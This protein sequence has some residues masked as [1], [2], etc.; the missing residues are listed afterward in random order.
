MDPSGRSRHSSSDPDLIGPS[1]GCI[2]LLPGCRCPL[3]VAVAAPPSSIPR[4]PVVCTT[5]VFVYVAMHKFT[6]H[7]CVGGKK[8]S[9][10]K[11]GGGSTVGSTNRVG[12]SISRS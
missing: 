1:V 4:C 11:K 8:E 7:R 3:S 5:Y 2:V 9:E 10:G 12:R 6:D